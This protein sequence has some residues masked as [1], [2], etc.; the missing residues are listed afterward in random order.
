MNIDDTFPADKDGR[1]LISTDGI[2]KVLAKIGELETRVEQLTQS[3]ERLEST[4]EDYAHFEPGPPCC[5]QPFEECPHGKGFETLMVGSKIV[6]TEEFK[7]AG[8]SISR[9]LI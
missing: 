7:Q 1:R 2:V 3:L 6:T 5:D 8:G 4:D 9:H